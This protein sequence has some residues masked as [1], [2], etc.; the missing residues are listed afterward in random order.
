MV[1]FID[2]HTHIDGEEFTEDLAEVVQRA[3][4]AGA[5]KLFVPGINA[6]SVETIKTVC[7]QFPDYCYGMIGLHP[8]DVRADY[9]E[10]I[11]AMQS[12]LQADEAQHSGNG[13]PWIAIGEIGLDFYW[14][15]EFEAEQLAAFEMQVQWAVEARLP[16]M[17]HCRKAQNEMV[18]ILRKYEG[19]LPGGVFH[20]FTGNA[21]EAEELLAFDGFVLGIGGVLTFKKSNLPETLAAAVPLNRIVLET[22]APYMAPVPHRGSRNESAYIVHVIDKLAEVYGVTPEDVGRI[23]TENAESVFN[24]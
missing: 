15:R 12:T 16:L 20:C 8:E 23:T 10:V 19:R 1:Q 5:V 24:S 4:D 3:K 7:R 6:S 14:S 17:I 9:A 11:A 18:K 13:R 2:T 22:D 21:H